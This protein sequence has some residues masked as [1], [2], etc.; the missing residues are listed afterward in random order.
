MVALKLL[1][2]EY[3]GKWT[4]SSYWRNKECHWTGQGPLLPSDFCS[5]LQFQRV[6]EITSEKF[7]RRQQRAMKGCPS[8][9]CVR[10]ENLRLGTERIQRGS[11]PFLEPVR[12]AFQRLFTA[13]SRCF[14]CCVWQDAE[15]WGRAALQIK[16]NLFFEYPD[17]VIGNVLCISSAEKL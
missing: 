8:V 4:A 7:K 9:S 6:F 5:S 12:Q 15:N 16:S 10:M 13:T 3:A 14:E 1:L 17:A 2:L 11:V